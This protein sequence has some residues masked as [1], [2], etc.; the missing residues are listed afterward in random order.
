MNRESIQTNKILYR[1]YF[2]TIPI[3]C[4]STFRR[5]FRVSS[6]IF[7]KLNFVVSAH[8]LYFTQRHD[9]ADLLRHSKYQKITVVMRLP[10]Y[11]VACDSIDEKLYMQESSVHESMSGFFDTLNFCFEYDYLRASMDADW[12]WILRQLKAR[13][14]PIC[15][16]DRLL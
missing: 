2:N 6:I 16:F 13:G 4:H 1:H 9:C 14:V 12:T 15:G 3:Y 7:D 10:S 11:C 8:D 5:H